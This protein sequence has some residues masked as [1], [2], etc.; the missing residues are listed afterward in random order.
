MTEMDLQNEQQEEAALAEYVSV[1]E[2]LNAGNLNR[3]NAVCSQDIRF[4]DPFNE[5]VGI[6]RFHS[7]MA[8]MFERLSGVRFDVD[9][10]Q[11]V[12]DSA[13]LHWTFSASSTATGA[14]SFTG[15]SRLQFDA[16]GLVCLHED[17]WDSAEVL[18]RLPILG[19]VLRKIKARCA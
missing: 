2:N 11:R 17:Y 16:R 15:V 5:V 6:E 19:V 18:S 12:A 9:H 1:L 14:F 4:S 8:E 10:A 13:Y 3:L 7:I